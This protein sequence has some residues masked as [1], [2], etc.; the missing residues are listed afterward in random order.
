MEDTREGQFRREVDS[1]WLEGGSL[2]IS[3]RGHII[4]SKVNIFNIRTKGPT[5]DAN[6]TQNSI[7]KIP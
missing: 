2:R 1:K 4:I 6:E 7:L 5:Y 3:A